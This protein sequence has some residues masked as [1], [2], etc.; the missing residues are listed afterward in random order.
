MQS[1]QIKFVYFGGEPI[2]APILRILI[3]AGLTPALVIC[4]PDRPAGRGH[5]LTP[6]PVKILAEEYDISVWQPTDF[7]DQPA[8]TQKLQDYDLFVVVA[9][10]RILPKW[11][12]E[13]PHHKTINVHPSMLPLRRG[14]N[15][16]RSAIIEDDR[17]A[18]GVSIMLMDEKMDHGPLLAQRHMEIA[19]EQWPLSGPELDDALAHMGGTML[20]NII[21]SWT[22]GEI[23]P[24]AQNHEH[25]TYTAK[26]T[27]ADGELPLD[28]HNLPTG[29][30][31]ARVY[32]TIQGL[33]G[34]P[35]TFFIHN[36]TRIKINDATIKD[37]RLQLTTITP[38]GKT[39]QQFDQWLPSSN[40]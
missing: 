24:S 2:G 13:L 32:R 17:A 19:D 9:Y 10:N 11:L 31:A 36:G 29:E 5:K 27:K 4:N 38:E 28:P 26:L 30:E 15:P 35:G 33:R 16:I 39:S 37:G 3:T 40:R 14:P 6:P 12:I 20:A 7:K 34:W 22:A 8:I 1:N 18:I 21:P 25:A 23:A